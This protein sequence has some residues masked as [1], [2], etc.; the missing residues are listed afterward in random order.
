M[1]KWMRMYYLAGSVSFNAMYVRIIL[2]YSVCRCIGAVWDGR[3][4]WWC[5]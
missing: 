3:W 1:F 2:D 4:D 5:M